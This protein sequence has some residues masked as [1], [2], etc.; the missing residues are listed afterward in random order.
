MIEQEE[1]KNIN[2]EVIKR[3]EVIFLLV[4]VC[5]IMLLLKC[6]VNF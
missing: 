4:E 2:E 5:M 6:V 3:S 1:L